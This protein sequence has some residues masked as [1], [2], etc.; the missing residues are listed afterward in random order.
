MRKWISKNHFLGKI[1]KLFLENLFMLQKNRVQ[2]RHTYNFLIWK[3]KKTIFH[4]CGHVYLHKIYKKCLFSNE[5]KWFYQ[6]LRKRSEIPLPSRQ[7]LYKQQ[8]YTKAWWNR[9]LSWNSWK[10]LE[11]QFLSMEITQLIIVNYLS[12]GFIRVMYSLV[13][14]TRGAPNKSMVACKFFDLL[15]KNARFWP[16]LANF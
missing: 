10:I 12:R 5:M 15:H 1:P 4:C 14:N 11:N 6:F 7:L 9:G 16:F 2:R 13:P 8:S 3:K